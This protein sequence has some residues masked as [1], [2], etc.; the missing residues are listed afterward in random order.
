MKPFPF[1][2]ALTWC[3]AALAGH[4]GWAPSVDEALKLGK[5]QN[6]PI[7]I[8]F[9]SPYCGP[10]AKMEREVFTQP[11]IKQRMDQFVKAKANVMEPAM[12]ALLKKHG[13]H[14][15]PSFLYLRPTGTVVLKISQVPR[16][17]HEF[18][19]DLNY[20][21]RRERAIASAKRLVAAAPRRASAHCRL[22]KAYLDANETQLAKDEFE[23]ALAAG[24]KGR[25]AA[26]ANFHLGR[27][28]LAQGD[29]E[30]AA[31][32]FDQTL[33]LD[34]AN[35]SKLA[36]PALL[37]RGRL[38]LQQGQYGP[39]YRC[40]AKII[41]VYDQDKKVVNEAQALLRECRRRMGR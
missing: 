39:A 31:K 26:E 29:R 22:G 38:A 18:L 15:L 36:G 20:V 23:K 4:A 17:P 14:Q 19:G 8:E 30:A 16:L 37:E 6:K 5:A 32:R 35:A 10:C 12:K 34:P 3:A 27:I 21:L 1:A 2:A 11:V 24:A 28:L 25:T 7:L 9:T 40:F 13:F 41:K 33:R